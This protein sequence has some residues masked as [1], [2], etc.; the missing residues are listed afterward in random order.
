[1]GLE[2]QGLLQPIFQECALQLFSSNLT[3]AVDSFNARLE[4]HKCAPS[5]QHP[6]ALLGCAPC[7][8]GYCAMGSAFD[9]RAGSERW[10][11]S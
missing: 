9:A 8:W 1:V 10:R 11:S 5:S 3:A 7:C 6:P 2:F 4:S